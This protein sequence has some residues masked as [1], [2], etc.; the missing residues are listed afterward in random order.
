MKYVAVSGGADS[1][2][3]ALLMYER[4]EE[5]EMVF[6]DTGAE[7]PETYYTITRVANTLNKTLIVV[8][9]GTFYQHLVKFGFMLPAPFCRWCT[10]V[11]KR[12][13]QDRFF[14]A[15]KNAVVA[16]GIRADEA[17]RLSKPS[18]GYEKIRPLVEAGMDKKDVMALCR[19]H[20]LLNPVYT[21]RH[22]VSCFC[23]FFQPKSDWL[24]LLKHHPELYMLA[25]QWEE[26]SMVW[27][28]EHGGTHFTWREGRTLKGLRMA[29]EQ[30]LRLWPE[31]D[32]EPCS[33]CSW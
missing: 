11:L 24:G 1:T 26:Q 20:D 30:Q 18:G 6:A 31:P 10:G 9:D 27:A 2:A 19:R 16:I 13:P 3:L 23:C 29:D 4:G 33:I 14:R 21:W 5:F 12:V 17:H 15:Q 8:G 32:E 7:L 28:R 25:E 22:S